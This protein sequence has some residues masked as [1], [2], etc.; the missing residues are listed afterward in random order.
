MGFMGTVMAGGVAV[1]LYPPVRLADLEEH[2][3]RQAGILGNAS[4]AVPVAFPEVGGVA[5]LLGRGFRPC[6]W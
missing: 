4:A 6:G 2:L 1:P 3:R 5:R